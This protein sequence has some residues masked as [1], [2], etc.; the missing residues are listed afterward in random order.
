M[1]HLF[2]IWISSWGGGGIDGNLTPKLYDKIDDLH[3]FVVNFLK[4]M[5]LHHLYIYIF[6]SQ[7]MLYVRTCS[8]Y[9]QFLIWSNLS[10]SVDKTGL[11]AISIEVIFSCVLW[12]IQ[13]TLSVNTILHWVVINHPNCLRSLLFSGLRQRTRLVWPVNRECSFLRGTWSYLCFLRCFFLKRSVFIRLLFC[14][15]PLD[16]LYFEHCSLSPPVMFI[17]KSSF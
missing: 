3:F 10:E 12:S 8:T 17:G 16:F 7:L 14:I 2:H 1:R 11:S 15:L 4:L 5:F 9:E 6:V 13:R